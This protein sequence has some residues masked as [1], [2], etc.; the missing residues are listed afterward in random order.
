[1]HTDRALADLI[2]DVAACETLESLVCGKGTPKPAKQRVRRRAGAAGASRAP[3]KAA[4]FDTFNRVCVVV[5]ACRA[6]RKRL[7]ERTAADAL[8]DAT[9][10]KLARFTDGAALAP[11]A[12][13]LH[14]VP[15]LVNI[16]RSRP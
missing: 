7:R 8:D 9:L 6:A 5:D 1:M 4:P 12:P 16:V 3:P 13:F 15:R 14:L 10:S 2:S 11:Y